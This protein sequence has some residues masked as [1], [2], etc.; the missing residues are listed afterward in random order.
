MENI[1][2]YYNITAT[3]AFII[4]KKYVVYQDRD[5]PEFTKY[6]AELLAQS[7]QE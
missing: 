3:P 1:A 2:D 6:M 7:K 4:N 5:F